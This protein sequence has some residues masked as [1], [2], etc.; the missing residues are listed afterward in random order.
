MSLVYAFIQQ[1]RDHNV[2]SLLSFA[3]LEAT[4]AN[5]I[6]QANPLT[7]QTVAIIVRPK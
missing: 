6:H 5:T 3:G 7:M 4:P 1:H 2:I